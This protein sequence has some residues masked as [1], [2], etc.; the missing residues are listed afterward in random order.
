MAG[1]DADASFTVQNGVACGQH[2][3][4]YVTFRFNA[5]RQAFLFRSRIW[6]SWHLNPSNEP[7]AAAPVR[8][9]GSMTRADPRRPVTFDAYRQE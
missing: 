8:D 9:A 3:T 1:P 7:G 5:A 4:D 2:W 6:K